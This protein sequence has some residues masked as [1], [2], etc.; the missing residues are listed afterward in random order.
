MFTILGLVIGFLVAITMVSAAQ[1]FSVSPTSFSESK[2]AGASGSGTITINNTGSES[3]NL[4]LTKTNLASGSN[5]ITLSISSSSVT[6][7]ASSS[8]STVTYSYSTTSSQSA[9]TYAASIVVQNAQNSSQTSTIPITV[10]LSANSSSST[11]NN[12]S[13]ASIVIVNH[14]DD[15]TLELSGEVDENIDKSFR[16]KNI[17]NTSLNVNS[18][19]FTNLEGDDDDIDSDEIDI[20]DDSFDLDIGDTQKVV[21]EIDIPDD[22][23][24]D[25]YEGTMRVSTTQGYIFNYT[26]SLEVTA[27]DLDVF[28][29]DNGAD[30]RSRVLE[31][32]GE[33]GETVDNYEVLIENDGNIDLQ[34]MYLEVED[35]LEEEF[36]SN[37]IPVSAIS[38]NPSTIDIDGGDDDTVE[39]KVSIPETQSSGTYY[40][41]LRVKTSDGEELDKM[42]LKV[43]VIGDIYIKSIELD[44]EV[45]PGDVLEVIVEVANQASKVQQNVKVSGRLEDIDSI[46][47]DI[48][49][50]TSTFLIDSKES[51]EQRLRFKIPDDATDGSHTLEITVTFDDDELVEVEE[52]IVNRPTYKI[53]VDSFTITPAIAKCDVD[54][55]TFTKVKNLGKYEDDV[56]ITAEIKDTGIKAESSLF[57]LEVDEQIQRNLRLDI[58]SLEPGVY[59]VTEKISYGSSTFEKKETQFRVV[60]CSDTVGIDVKPIEPI[61]ETNTTTPVS[62]KVTILGNEMEKTTAILAGTTVAVFGFIVLALFFI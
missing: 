7:L 47:S 48:T 11:S 26:I 1:S 6:N 52:V 2:T 30:A 50:T 20:D 55:Y 40:G 45:T 33:A 57:E 12:V 32:I 10:V 15:D 9:G 34:D 27:D 22:V 18:I 17:G 46:N 3:I 60:E 23:A 39:V 44:N 54:L 16:F 43:K 4:S 41:D 37:T 53:S 56:K 59:T 62:S 14:D 36:T 5:S 38:F 49:D 51:R 61:N 21:I 8:T 24:P 31:M 25:T 35:A 28:F 58:S 29:V 42:T 13:G 19:S